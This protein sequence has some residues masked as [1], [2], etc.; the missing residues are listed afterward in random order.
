MSKESV[1]HSELPAYSQRVAALNERI[2]AL[3]HK[4]SK[5][6][7]QNRL[8]Q[9]LRRTRRNRLVHKGIEHNFPRCRLDHLRRDLISDDP[10]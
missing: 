7:P 5:R 8:G 3:M 10:C 2:T 9:R 4:C 6:C 1:T